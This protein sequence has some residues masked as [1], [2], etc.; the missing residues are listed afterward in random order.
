MSYNYIVSINYCGVLKL[1]L[2]EIKD[3][4]LFWDKNVTSLCQ[5]KCGSLGVMQIRRS[6]SLER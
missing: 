2:L 4:L 6:G 5:L 3:V 1:P